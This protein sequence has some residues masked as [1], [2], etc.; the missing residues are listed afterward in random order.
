M[1]SV[2]HTH[3]PSEYFFGDSDI[4]LRALK[5]TWLPKLKKTSDDTFQ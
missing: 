2:E 5:K 3:P 4:G 1:I